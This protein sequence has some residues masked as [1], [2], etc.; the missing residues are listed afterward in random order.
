MYSAL[1]LYIDKI[2]FFAATIPAGK[3]GGACTA[4]QLAKLNEN[5]FFFLPHWW[6]Y[7]NTFKVDALNQCVPYVTFPTSV[8]PVGLAVLDML[9][10]IAGFAAVIMIMVAG[11][12][13][14]AAQGNPEKAASARKGI[15]NALIGL[16]I[17]FTATL[18]V[19]FIGN[20][21]TK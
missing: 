5:S 3:P 8:F 20:S 11:I 18:F 10:R 13:Y 16:G 21:L 9:L 14:I 19:A 17:A 2:L 7:M 4:D 6:Q 12:Q 1:Y 15:Y